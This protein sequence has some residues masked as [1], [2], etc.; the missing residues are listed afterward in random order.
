MMAQ[1]CQ[2]YPETNAM[3]ERAVPIKRMAEPEEIADVI[4]F[5]CSPQ[6][7]YMNGTGESLFACKPHLR[8]SVCYRTCC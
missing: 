4:A 2:T 8:L 1:T 3:I 5:M 7:S 6:A